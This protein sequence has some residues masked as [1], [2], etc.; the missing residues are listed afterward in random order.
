MEVSDRKQR[1]ALELFNSQV[2]DSKKTL[3]N[4]EKDKQNKADYHARTLDK[5]KV[6]CQNQFDR[7]N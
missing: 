4:I 6:K 3:V 2:E 7:Q 1:E 5:V